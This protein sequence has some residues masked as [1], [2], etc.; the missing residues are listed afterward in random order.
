MKAVG[1]L[2]NSDTQLK[3]PF[4]LTVLPCEIAGSHLI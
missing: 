1:A 2:N 4:Q 3:N